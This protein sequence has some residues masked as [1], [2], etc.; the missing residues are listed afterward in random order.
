M[1]RQHVTAKQIHF[2]ALMLAALFGERRNS[3][4]GRGSGHR[5]IDW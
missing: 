1:I 4:S 3:Q 2:D 5:K